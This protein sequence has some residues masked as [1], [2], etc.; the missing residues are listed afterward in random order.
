MPENPN[1][2]EQVGNVI[3]KYVENIVGTNAG[4]VTGMIID[5]PIEDIKP[6]M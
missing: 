5:L 3:Y 1:Y 6:I 4:K 2:K